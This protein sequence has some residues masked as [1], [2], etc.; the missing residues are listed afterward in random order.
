MRGQQRAGPG[1]HSFAGLGKPF[2]ALA[3][4]DQH[5]IQLI[6]QIAQTHRQ[7]RLGN[8]AA[9]GGLAEVSGFVQRDQELGCLMSTKAPAR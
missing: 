2:K 9:G 4:I 6:F 3:A 8:V 1:Q 5:Q 7:G